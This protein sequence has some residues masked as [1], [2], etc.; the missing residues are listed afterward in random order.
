MIECAGRRLWIR[1][2]FFREIFFSFLFNYHYDQFRNEHKLFY[3]GLKHWFVWLEGFFFASCVCTW[4]FWLPLNEKI[5]VKQWD[6]KG[7]KEKSNI[8][9]MTKLINICHSI[10]RFNR[11]FLIIF[12]IYFWKLSHEFIKYQEILF[13]LYHRNSNKRKMNEKIW[14]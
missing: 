11:R 10:R 8:W 2:F 9:R 3:Y 6:T 1:F 4:L 5:T 14:K 13:K 7:K 12:V